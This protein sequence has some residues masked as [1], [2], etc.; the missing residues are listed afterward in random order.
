MRIKLRLLGFPLLTR[1]IGKREMDFELAGNT[2]G[3]LIEE[4]LARYGEK[5]EAALLDIDGKFDQTI[6][7]LLNEKAYVQPHRLNT[8]VHPGDEVTLMIM[9]LGG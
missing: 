6:R 5:A 7:I 1:V 4:I 9:M 2:V 3:D 8:I